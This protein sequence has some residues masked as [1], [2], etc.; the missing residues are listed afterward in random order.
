MGFA[1]HQVQA[2]KP[3]SNGVGAILAH[4]GANLPRAT[5]PQRAESVRAASQAQCRRS[6]RSPTSDTIRAWVSLLIVA[7]RPSPE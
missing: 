4:D 3:R 7:I 6:V 1:G 2:A 5:R